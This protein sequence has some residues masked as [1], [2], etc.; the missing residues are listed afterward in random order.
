[1]LRH[2]V[3]HDPDNPMYQDYNILKME[4]EEE[5]ME[6]EE[7]EVRANQNLGRI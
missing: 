5:D 7:E 1:M 6:E 4:E 3:L 2:M